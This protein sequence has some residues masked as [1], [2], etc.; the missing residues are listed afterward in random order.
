MIGL[1][2]K[3]GDTFSQQILIGRTLFLIRS[4]EFV[5]NCLHSFPFI[6]FSIV[7]ADGKEVPPVPIPNTAVKLFY[8]E[9][10]WLVTAWKIR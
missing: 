4:I 8:V 10:T 5:L 3:R 9:N 1:R 7:G 2:C 6:L